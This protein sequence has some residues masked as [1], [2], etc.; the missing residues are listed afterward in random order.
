MPNL[1]KNNDISSL[2]IHILAMLIVLSRGKSR[3]SLRGQLIS[4]RCQKFLCRLLLHFDN[5][6]LYNKAPARSSQKLV[7]C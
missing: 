6:F 1:S 2:E 7:S 3:P 4:R 5:R